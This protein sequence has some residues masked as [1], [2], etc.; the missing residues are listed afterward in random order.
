[1]NREE[2]RLGIKNKSMLLSLATMLVLSTAS[3][4]APAPLA[5]KELAKQI[6]TLQMQKPE[7]QVPLRLMAPENPSEIIRIIVELEK[8]PA[9]ETATKKGKLYKDLPK[10]E[11]KGLEASIQADQKKVKDKVKGKSKNIKFKE[12]FATVF[13]GFS[14]EVTA[15]EVASIAQTEGVKAVYATNEYTRPNEEPNMVHS[16][17]LVQAQLAWDQYDFINCE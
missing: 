8:A 1:M 2:S 9:I 10:S 15:G 14:A 16:K 17:E 5:A 3:F 11:R 12:E 4:G 6:P 7:L 13:N